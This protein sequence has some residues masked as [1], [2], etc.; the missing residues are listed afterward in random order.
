MT[1]RGGGLHRRRRDLDERL[2]GCR[3]RSG[4]EHRDRGHVFRGRARHVQARFH[5]S[6]FFGL[7]WEVDDVAIG[8]VACS[9]LPGGLVVGSVSNANTGLGLSGATVTDL[10]DDSSATTVAAPARATALLALC[11][12]QRLAGFRSRGG[13]PYSLTKNA[14]VTA[15]AVVR[16]DFS[17]AAGLLDAG[18]R[19]LSAV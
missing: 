16:L 7:W 12:G 18:P 2:E 4:P 9:T 10:G 17:L 13:S 5:Y 8:P 6:A 11:R 1:R 14:D 19:P 3:E 15:D